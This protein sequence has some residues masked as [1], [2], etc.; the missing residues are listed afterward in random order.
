MK[1]TIHRKAFIAIALLVPAPTI[2]VLCGMIW[3][4]DTALGTGLFFFCKVWLLAFPLVWRLLIDKKPV[5][6]SPARKGGWLAGILTG[7]LIA[8]VILGFWLLLG[9][10]LIDPEFVRA[11][12]AA[13]GL[14]SLPRY[15][16]MIAYW[17]II[18]SLLEEYVWRWF[19]TEKFHLL[20]RRSWIAVALSAAAFTLHHIVAMSVYFDALPTALC[21]FFI[22]VGGAIWSALYLRYESIRPAYVSHIFADLAI[23][24]IDGLIL[25]P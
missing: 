1:N 12:M 4:P 16:G 3:L 5:S 13:I 2:G 7:L 19:I 10:K 21:A 17:I 15:L 6:L 23:F 22:F 8:G 18:N 14:T 20:F 25:F 11:K 24:L 9:P